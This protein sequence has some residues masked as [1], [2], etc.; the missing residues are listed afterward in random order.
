MLWKGKIMVNYS[1]RSSG[2]RKICLQFVDERRI[3]RDESRYN[4]P[5]AKRCMGKCDIPI[6][7]EGKICP[8]CGVALRTRPRSQGIT[9]INYRIGKQVKYY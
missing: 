9:M 5:N 2:C 4:L 1:E 3:K 7:Y 6:I 8:C